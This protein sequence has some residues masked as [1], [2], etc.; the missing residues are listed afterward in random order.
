MVGEEPFLRLVLGAR[1][2]GSLQFLHSVNEGM[3]MKLSRTENILASTSRALAAKK[4]EMGGDI[5]AILH[6]NCVA[7][8]LIL[9][10]EGEAE[11]FCQLFKG[12]HHAGFSSHGEIYIA[13][14]NQT[15]TMLLFG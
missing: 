15:S 9:E 12:C 4:A 14:A 8:Q 7:R 11:Q 6:F 3:R 13:I 1:P 10:K 5:S 2:D